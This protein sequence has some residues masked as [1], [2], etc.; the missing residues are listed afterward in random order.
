[1]SKDWILGFVEAEGSFYLVNK[2]A[3][4]ITHGFGLTQKL[5]RHCLEAIARILHIKTSVKYKENKTDNNFYSLDT[6]NSRAIENIIYYFKN[7]LKGIK[8]FEY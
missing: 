1:M 4:R 3:N 2:T 7:Q 8:S 5:D 6:T